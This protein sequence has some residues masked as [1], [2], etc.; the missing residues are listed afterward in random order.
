MMLRVCSTSSRSQ[1]LGTNRL[2]F[3][4]FRT[5]LEDIEALPVI[6]TRIGREVDAAIR[7]VN[8]NT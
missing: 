7:P 6:V 4:N 1:L 2:L 3:V 5:S 8:L